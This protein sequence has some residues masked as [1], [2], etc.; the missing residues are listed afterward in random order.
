[1]AMST[2][3]RLDAAEQQDGIAGLQR[4]IQQSRA[5]VQGQAAQ[6]RAAQAQQRAAGVAGDGI[7]VQVV[8]PG[9]RVPP[10]PAT[11]GHCVTR[12]AGA[13]VYTDCR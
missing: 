1:M 7:G 3:A 8:N 13:N 5:A 9:E 10:G 2:A 11:P 12:Y 6:T 4:S